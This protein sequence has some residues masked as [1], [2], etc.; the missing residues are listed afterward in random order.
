MQ[1]GPAW[2]NYR[3]FVRSVGLITRTP[4]MMRTM[5][6]AAMADIHGNLLALEAV[7]A[8]VRHYAPDLILNLGDH[9]SGP[10]WAAGT[11][12]LL[13]SVSDWVQIRGNHD[14]QLVEFAPE[15]MGKS[16]RAAWEQLTAHHKSG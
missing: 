8:D 1:D 2:K 11:A 14:R 10:L 6:I 5:R 4:A 12:D 9:V 16:D 15:A 3:I 13:M 7:I